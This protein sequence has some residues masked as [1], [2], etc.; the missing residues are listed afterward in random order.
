MPMKTR[1]IPRS[2]REMRES[3]RPPPPPPLPHA[4]PPAPVAPTVLVPVPIPQSVPAPT[5]SS[6]CLYAPYEC[7]VY[8]FPPQWCSMCQVRA[9][10]LCAQNGLP[11]VR[12]LFHAPALCA[13]PI[14][15]PCETVSRGCPTTNH[16]LT[17]CPSP[18]IHPPTACPAQPSHCVIGTSNAHAPSH[19]FCTVP[20]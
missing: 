3:T 6:F 15:R 2:R 8:R 12:M 13:P 7:S 4:G 14:F 5:V 9:A 20:T 17:A 18:P 16:C 19:A 1:R 11:D 10:S